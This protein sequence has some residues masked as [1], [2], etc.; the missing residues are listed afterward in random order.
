MGITTVL[1]YIVSRVLKSLNHFA[2]LI[3]GMS[4]RAGPCL[5]VVLTWPIHLAPKLEDQ[6]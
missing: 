5:Q 1:C 6:E 2:V 4:V 3:Q